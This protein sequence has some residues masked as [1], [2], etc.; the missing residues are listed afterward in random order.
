MTMRETL[1]KIAMGVSL[2]QAIVIAGLWLA[3]EYGQLRITLFGPNLDGSTSFWVS[4]G[5]LSSNWITGGGGTPEVEFSW[6]VRNQF[7]QWEV[8]DFGPT[9]I[10]DPFAYDYGIV[11][12]GTQPKR[13]DAWKWPFIKVE[14]DD[15]GTPQLRN[16]SLWFLIAMALLW[17]TWSVV[18]SLRRTNKR[19]P[20]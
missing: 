19:R 10:S 11:F 12:Q 20:R 6:F 5:T 3:S 15:E 7:G 2:F 8:S 17:P 9:K 18:R 13:T 4:G 1:S 16:L 14:I